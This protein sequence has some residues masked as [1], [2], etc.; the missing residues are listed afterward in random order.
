MKEAYINENAEFGS[1]CQLIVCDE[2]II[3]SNSE[4]KYIPLFLIKLILAGI[5]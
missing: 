5:F 1:N 4:T 3:C 2:G